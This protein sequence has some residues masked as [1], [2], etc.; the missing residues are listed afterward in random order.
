MMQ[1][2]KSSKS[3]KV[4]IVTYYFPP[5][6][7]AGVQRILKFVKYLPVFGWEPIVLAPR[8]ADYPAY[9]ETLLNDVPPSIKIYRASIIEPYKFYRKLTGKN[10]PSAQ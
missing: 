8:D 1:N 3:K 9:D 4:L 10:Q 2:M 6:G 5:S 7:G